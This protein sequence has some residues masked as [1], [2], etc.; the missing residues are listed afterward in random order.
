MGGNFSNLENKPAERPK[1]IGNP[2]TTIA[3]GYISERVGAFGQSHSRTVASP[4]KALNKG[5]QISQAVQQA[6]QAATQQ[7]QPQAQQPQAPPQAAP[8]PQVQQAGVPQQV[9]QPLVDSF[10]SALSQ[11]QIDP[12]DVRH[13]SDLKDQ[14]P[15]LGAALPIGIQDALSQLEDNLDLLITAGS[16][17]VDPN[18]LLLAVDRSFVLLVVVR[19]FIGE[20]LE[21]S[22]VFFEMASVDVETIYKVLWW[23][24][25]LMK[26][27]AGLGRLGASALGPISLRLVPLWV[28]VKELGVIVEGVLGIEAP[29]PQGQVIQQAV[30]QQTQYTQPQQPQQSQPEQSQP[31]QAP[32][33]PRTPQG[34]PKE[35]MQQIMQQLDIALN[36]SQAPTMNTGITLSG[37]KTL[38]PLK[39]FPIGQ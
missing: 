13:W 24:R 39:P 30:V 32:Q 28:K 26:E 18:L 33:A 34:Q 4:P 29:A 2:D 31:Q 22:P 5:L 3:G 1:T 25:E 35:S 21:N 14:D 9:Q 38:P 11:R 15:S 8:Q 16:Q 23:A 7:A 27:L 6:P 20:N 36:P 10:L 37:E 19:E 17:L 12:G